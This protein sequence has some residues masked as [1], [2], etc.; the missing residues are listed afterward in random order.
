M[1][2]LSSLLSVSPYS[3]CKIQPSVIP[4]N[5]RRSVNNYVSCKA[6]NNGEDSVNKF[7]RRDMLFGLGNLYGV[8][9]LSGKDIALADDWSLSPDVHNCKPVKPSAVGKKMDCC[10][11]KI[12]EIIEFTPPVVPTPRV[13]PAV[14]L[15]TPDQIADL[16]K[17]IQMMKMLPEDDPRSFAHQAKV[18]CAY[19][20][21]A[22]KQ[23]D[24]TMDFQVHENALFFP[25]HRAYL[26]FFER[27]LCHL[28]EKP[29]FAIPFWN[30]DAPPGMCMPKIY[31]K[32][33][34]S[35]YDENRDKC[36]QPP[37]LLNLNYGG[38]EVKDPEIVDFNLRWMNDQMSVETA[39]EFLGKV[40]KRGNGPENGSGSI[41]TSPH[42]N[43]HIWVGDPEAT[44]HGE[45]MGHFY[46]AGRD[47]L[48]YAHHANVDRMW[49]IWQKM[50]DRP[51][52]HTDMDWLN[53]SFVLYD[54]NRKAVRIKVSQCL[55][56]KILGY[57]YQ[58]VPIPWKD[59]P[60]IRRPKQERSLGNLPPTIDFPQ[61]LSSDITTMVDR[62]EVASPEDTI[63][64]NEVLVLEDVEYDPTLPLHFDVLLNVGDE[65][66]DVRAGHIEFVGTFTNV[67]H[68]R[69]TYHK[70]SLHFVITKKIQ[71]LGLEGD[72][73]VAVKI[74]PNVN[75][76]DR[77]K[78]GGIKIQLED[79]E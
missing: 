16:E 77:I 67:P 58:D 40:I 3:G 69:T 37:K 25:F 49:N 23:M 45:D 12:K 38:K 17:G 50:K 43:I 6:S 22:Y 14:H 79:I 11:P 73:K 8:A 30:W 76:G 51:R 48:F 27:I 54:E 59:T 4:L 60:P 24:S 70:T 33:S 68:G 47:P 57:V 71:Q 74:V 20:D 44:I 21:D 55:D 78:I 10:P 63:N 7:D 65:G 75:G 62:P 53:S 52:D 29:D 42:N 34:S 66:E 5:K 26:Y 2:S 61:I 1:A 19:C 32:P 46:S 9:T 35:L 28:L 18:H 13:R 64:K 39:K 15:M 72:K 31:T 56:S 41:E 36:H